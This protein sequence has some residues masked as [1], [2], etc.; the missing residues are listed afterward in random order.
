MYYE[1]IYKRIIAAISIALGAGGIVF[2]KKGINNLKDFINNLDNSSQIIIIGMILLF[3]LLMAVFFAKPIILTLIRW[4]TF[5]KI[6]SEELSDSQTINNRLTKNETESLSET[7]FSEL[8]EIDKESKEDFEKI[9][10][11]ADYQEKRKKEK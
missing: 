7:M 3:V 4:L 11:I 8:N 6:H 1:K 9:K 5:K 10:K 2:I